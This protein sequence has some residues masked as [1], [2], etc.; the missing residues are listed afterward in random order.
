VASPLVD[1]IVGI[2]SNAYVE[3]V[4]LEALLS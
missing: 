2:D 4:L 1:D 3:P